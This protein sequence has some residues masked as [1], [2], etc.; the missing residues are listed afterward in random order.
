LF[1]LG[2]SVLQSIDSIWQ[3]LTKSLRQW[4][5]LPDS[6]SPSSISPS[7]QPCFIFN[8]LTSYLWFALYTQAH[9]IQ[10]PLCHVAVYSFAICHFLSVISSIDNLLDVGLSCVPVQC[11][12]ESGASILKRGVGPFASF[13]DTMLSSPLIW[14]CGHFQTNNLNCSGQ[15]PVLDID[16][17]TLGF[18]EY[19]K[20]N[21][22]YLENEFLSFIPHD[23][24]FFVN[25]FGP[26]RECPLAR[27]FFVLGSETHYVRCELTNWL[28]EPT[29][30]FR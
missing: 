17:Q 24:P 6:S 27:V 1:L 23:C 3:A 11:T 26:E 29:R 7:P 13:M 19:T 9:C 15:L 22:L 20:V 16:I 28:F 12:Q 8:S 14:L 21:F 4:L 30:N 18:S 5:V 25:V 10:G 2:H